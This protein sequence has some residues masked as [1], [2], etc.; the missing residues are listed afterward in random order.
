M[1]DRY[2]DDDRRSGGREPR[3]GFDVS[4]TLDMLGRRL[5]GAIMVAG[6]LIGVGVYM[7]G[8]DDDEQ[9]YQAFAA[10][11]EVFRVNMESGTII[12]CN[13]KRCTRILQRGQDLEENGGGTLFQPQQPAALPAPAAPSAAPAQAPVPAQNP[14]QAK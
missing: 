2:D 8:G 9:T 7:S 6:A 1:P 14:P 10:D 12:A 13:A 5:G 3:S 4:E 11:G